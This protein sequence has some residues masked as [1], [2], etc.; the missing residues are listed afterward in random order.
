MCRIVL[1]DAER[2]R[3]GWTCWCLETEVVTLAGRLLDGQGFDCGTGVNGLLLVIAAKGQPAATRVANLGTCTRVKC[4]DIGAGLLG[5]R[6]S[7]SLLHR[8]NVSCV[9]ASHQSLVAIAA[10]R[11]KHRSTDLIR[12]K[13]ALVY[14]YPV[15]SIQPLLWKLRNDNVL[16][17]TLASLHAHWSIHLSSTIAANAA[18]PATTLV[19]QIPGPQ[20]LTKVGRDPLV[21]L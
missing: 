1:A 16:T 11:V 4:A 8:W 19:E 3:T 14:D 6:E 5:A 15:S 9:T 13:M 18:V 21:H 17:G 20:S 7:T 12:R 2:R 10:A